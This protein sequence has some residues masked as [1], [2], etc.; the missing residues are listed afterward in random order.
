MHM[1]PEPEAGLSHT[2]TYVTK[3]HIE[4]V[5]KPPSPRSPF[6]IEGE[7]LPFSRKYSAPEKAGP[8]IPSPILASGEV[9][10]GAE[11]QRTDG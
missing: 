7:E 11:T 3:S 5:P 8:S 10:Y 6:T 2:S 9:R 4:R 1:Q